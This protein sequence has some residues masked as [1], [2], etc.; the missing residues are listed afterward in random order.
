MT[1]SGSGGASETRR[2]PDPPVDAADDPR[3]LPLEVRAPTPEARCVE[4]SLPS[5]VDDITPT[6]KFFIRS[7]FAVPRLSAEEWQLS[8]EGEVDRPLTLGFEEFHVLPH[9]ELIT[10]MECAGNSRS[11]VRPKPEGVLWGHGAVST[12]RWRGVPLRSLLDRA[13][14]RTTAREAVLV[15]A[16]RGREPGL[17]GELSYE[18]SI[19]IQKALHP[20]TLLVDEMNGHPL[21]PSHG[22][23]VRALVPGYYGMASVKWITRVDVIDHSF[24]GYFRTRAYAYIRE[25]QRSSDPRVPATTIRVK[26]LINWPREG[27]ILATG[28]HV[29][30]GMAWSGAAP[31]VRVDVSISSP[32]GAGEVWHS[33]RLKPAPSRYSWTH[34][35][36]LCDLLDPGFYLVRARAT[37]E[38]GNAQPVQAEWNFRGI[39]NN[40]I[41]SVPIE[42]QAAG[43]PDLD[44]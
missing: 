2:K 11:T 10:T 4:A 3:F 38:L 36:L 22:F 28:P 43:P 13:G 35:D 33:A 21:S 44:A 17:S 18:M 42:V 8:I 26:S 16:D 32:T 29:I 1:T 41:H 15:G 7:H 5:L 6:N 27:Q 34:W 24:E 25:G 37:D 20:D 40:S 39:G 23:P 19:E 12:G 14:V 31:I 30:R 9:R